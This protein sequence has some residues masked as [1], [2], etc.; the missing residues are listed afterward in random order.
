MIQ[1][2]CTNPFINSYQCWF[3]I[4]CEEILVST[5]QYNANPGSPG[6]R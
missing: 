3:Y 5:R 4:L 2:E 1:D 6:F